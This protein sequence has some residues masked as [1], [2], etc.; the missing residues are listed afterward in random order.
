MIYAT[1]QWQ[2]PVLLLGK[3]VRWV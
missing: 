3:E 2:K 1:P